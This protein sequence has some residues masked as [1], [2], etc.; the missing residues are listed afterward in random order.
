MKEKNTT[1]TNILYS[2]KRK[3]NQEFAEILIG[4]FS[5]ILFYCC[6]KVP[7][8]VREVE[9]ATERERHTTEGRDTKMLAFGISCKIKIYF[10]ARRNICRKTKWKGFF[11]WCLHNFFLHEHSTSLNKE[12]YINRLINQANAF[13]VSL[14]VWRLLAIK[15]R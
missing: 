8:V 4:W 5:R 2:M 6:I 12:F 15:A 11:F 7:D 3:A 9:D 10:I 14:A 13:Q 1:T